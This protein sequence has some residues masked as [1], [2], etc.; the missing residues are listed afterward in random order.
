MENEND[1]RDRVHTLKNWVMDSKP[2]ICLE[3]LR[4]VTEVFEECITDPPSLLRAK[5]L[6][7]ILEEMPISIDDLSLFAGNI[8]TKPPRAGVITPEYGMNWVSEIDTID[9]RPV[10]PFYLSAEEKEEIKSYFPRWKGMSQTDCVE[11]V[12]PHQYDGFLNTMF[13]HVSGTEAGKGHSCVQMDKVIAIGLEGVKAEAEKKLAE[14]DPASG[15][16]T[17]S[18]YFYQGVII[19][20]DAIMTF[21][22][23]YSDLARELA[24]DPKT[25]PARKTELRKLAEI[26]EH[27]PAKPARSFYEALQSIWFIIIGLFNEDPSYALIPGRLDQTLYDLY[28]QDIKSGVLTRDGALELIAHWYVKI[29][30]PYIVLDTQTAMIFTGNPMT[31]NIAL[32]GQKED[33]SDATNE[34]SY[35][36]MEAEKET[37]LM[38]PDL[39]IRVHEKTPKDF[40]LKACE[41]AKDRIGKAKFL[42]DDCAI[43][44]MMDKGWSIEDA[45]N[46]VIVGCMAG[47]VAGKEYVNL[48]GFINSVKCLEL[49]L[50][51]GV[52]PLSGAQL[53]PATGDSSSFKTYEELRDAFYAQARAAN[54]NYI[55]YAN[56]RMDMF[57]KRLHMPLLTSLIDGG[58]EK[59]LDVGQNSIKKTVRGACVPGIATVSDSLAVIKKLVFE[60]KQVDMKQLLEALKS[61]FE[62]YDELRKKVDAV[63][64]FGNDIDYVDDIAKE[65]VDMYCTDIQSYRDSRGWPYTV[66]LQAVTGNIA[67]GFACGATPDGR[68]AGTPFND[69]ISPTQGRNVNGI[70]ASFK[71]ICKLNLAQAHQGSVVN[72]TISPAFVDT[73]EKMERF[74]ALIQTYRQLGGY[75]VQFNF[76]NTGMLKAAQ[77]NPEQYRD[78]MVRVST[79][80]TYFVELSKMVQD[81]IIARFEQSVS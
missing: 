8:T 55:G 27:V 41:L 58:L 51:N 10:D 14:I 4:L 44:T 79:Y 65:L 39:I 74:M 73:P 50:N 37:R 26:C 15:V 19:A 6:K 81:D 78:L 62:G 21:A 56:I 32:G 59:G 3:R 38:Q 13:S 17:S 29:N 80:S 46:Y 76:V 54:K 34:L 43:E 30:E 22:K 66:S 47:L 12:R 33:G 77:E 49:A 57:F 1:W 70:T 9:S 36:F 5:S 24:E 7:K 68:L 2:T 61:N 75:L 35:L 28:T 40:L 64:K 71:S 52:D 72:L 11:A 67:F 45:R 25:T 53:G 31:F 63:P 23:R 69:G 18:I 42:M 20:L 60:E 48:E 16:D